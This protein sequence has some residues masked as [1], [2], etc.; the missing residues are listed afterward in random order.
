MNDRRQTGHRCPHTA[1][2][3]ERFTVFD[4]N[5]ARIE[6]NQENEQTK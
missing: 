2:P 6:N 3:R 1:C 5:S 4:Q